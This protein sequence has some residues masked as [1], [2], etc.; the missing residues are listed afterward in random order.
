[1]RYAVSPCGRA[2]LRASES[3]VYS[4]SF[5]SHRTG[6]LQYQI[7]TFLTLMRLSGFIKTFESNCL[8]KFS[9]P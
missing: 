3:G 8:I 4:L 6:S 1:M 9:R 2:I 5:A 7:E